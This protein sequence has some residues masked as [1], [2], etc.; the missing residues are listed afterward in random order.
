MDIY[1]CRTAS[2][3]SFFI[4]FLISW[5]ILP[6]KTT[7]LCTPGIKEISPCIYLVELDQSVKCSFCFISELF[8]FLFFIT[9]K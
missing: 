6:T 1:R 3:V 9:E 8:E 5:I 4:R 2:K 7:E